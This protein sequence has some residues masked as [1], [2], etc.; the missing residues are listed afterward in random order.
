MKNR[1]LLIFI[2]KQMSKEEL[3]ITHKPSF[4]D[5]LL[6]SKQTPQPIKTKEY[7][8]I[9]V[10]KKTIVTIRYRD[11]HIQLTYQGKSLQILPGKRNLSKKEV[12]ELMKNFA[13]KEGDRVTFLRTFPYGKSRLRKRKKPPVM[14]QC[15]NLV[16]V[17]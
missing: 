7:Q 8:T 9:P 17:E 1:N 2:G 6:L 13:L 12:F 5:A 4:H 14:A 3:R 15:K 16:V 10:C 11:D